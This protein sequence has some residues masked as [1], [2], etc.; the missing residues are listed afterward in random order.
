MHHFTKFYLKVIDL[1]VAFIL[2]I[3]FAFVVVNGYVMTL[4]EPE[5]FPDLLTGI[6]W[7]MTTVTTIGY[8]DIYPVTELGKIY[9]M[10][11]VDLFG[12]GLFGVIIGKVVGVF[13]AFYQRKKE[14]KL[15][16]RGKDHYV[17]VGW[18][19]TSKLSVMELLNNNDKN[20]HIVLIAHLAE[21][22]LPDES[23]VHYVH[24]SPNDFSVLE[25]ANVQEASAI[26][27]FSP[28]HVE[29]AD[30][31][32]GYTLLVAT[33]VERYDEKFD[34][35]IYTVVEIQKSRHQENFKH[36][37]VDEFIL[38]RQSISLLMV[39]KATKSNIAKV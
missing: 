4:I 17:V 7:T 5:T 6:W 12:I 28:D 34:H 8:G 26:M 1:N 23:K 38:S 11:F 24:G 19:E 36:V 32:D 21:T 13:S 39:E 22:P 33:S 9:A 16:F 15:M 27:I 25:R 18:T 30:L 35:N 29:Q 14:G 3:G 20:L 31:A 10:V 37:K 2:L